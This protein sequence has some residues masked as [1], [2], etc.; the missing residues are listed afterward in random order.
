MSYCELYFKLIANFFIRYY[1]K[2]INFNSPNARTVSILLYCGPPR[3]LWRVSAYG[4]GLSSG[5]FYI[6]NVPAKSIIKTN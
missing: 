4:G 1:F 5:L 3:R 6:G 2:I